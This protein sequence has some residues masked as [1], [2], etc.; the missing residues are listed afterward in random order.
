MMNLNG[1]VQDITGRDKQVANLLQAQHI[2][3]AGMGESFAHKEKIIDLDHYQ[4]L[5]F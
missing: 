4:M 5:P 3:E 1:M 2:V